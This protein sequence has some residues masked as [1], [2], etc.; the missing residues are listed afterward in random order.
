M[1]VTCQALQ[2]AASLLSLC[3][4]SPTPP[5]P[6]AID[7]KE[8]MAWHDPIV[9]AGVYAFLIGNL[10]YENEIQSLKGA[11]KFLKR[12]NS[13]YQGTVQTPCNKGHL[14][15]NRQFPMRSSKHQTGS[16]D[17]SSQA[18]SSAKPQLRLAAS[19]GKLLVLGTLEVSSF[20]KG[21]FFPWW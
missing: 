8:D 12:Y 15:P 2:G 18:D 13:D 16:S 17:T 14:M 1:T 4:A 11:F 21:G 5:A 3:S 19:D 9:D 6:I 7:G 10:Q 20:P